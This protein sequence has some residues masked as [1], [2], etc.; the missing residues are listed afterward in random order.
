MKSIAAGAEVYLWLG[1][2]DMRAGFERLAQHVQE[3]LQRSVIGGGLY[4]FVSRCRKRVKILYWA[5]DGYALWYKRLEAGTFKVTQKDG[6]EVLSG[7]DLQELL[8]GVDLSRIILRKN[9]EKGLYSAA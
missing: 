3:Q 4:V 2:T 6:A 7:V 1:A 8:S 9:A 5:K